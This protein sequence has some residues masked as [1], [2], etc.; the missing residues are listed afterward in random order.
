MKK[1]SRVILLLLAI[2]T[3][4]NCT[5]AY[6]TSSS[7]TINKIN[8]KGYEI[9]IDANGGI[10]DSKSV[11]VSKNSTDLP[12]PKRT[13]YSFSGYSNSATGEVLYS[14]NITNI[15]SI[16]NNQIYAKWNANSYVVD[17]NPI[18]DGTAY[19]SGLAGYTFDV[20]V[21]EV[22]VADDVIDWYQSVTYGNPVR[23]KTNSITGRN[24]SYDK[25]F[26][27][28]A[29]QLNINPAWTI[30]TYEGHFYLNGTHRLTTYNK[31][32]STISTPNTSAS[33]LGYDANFY[34]ISGYTP[35]TTWTQPD[36]AVGF[37]INIAEYN[38]YASFG[39]AGSNNATYQNNKLINAGYNF[40]TVN[41]GWGAVEC[42]GNYSKI[43]NLYNN[44]WNILPRSGNG[45]SIYKQISC[46]SGWS[47]V[48]R[49]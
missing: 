22:Q 33:A 21:N 11:V 38:C 16:N 29:E 46:D 2:F 27:V 49:R 8:T 4:L 42:S 45:Y 43:M 7:K 10:F 3:T 15:D 14:N 24:T 25:T 39:N 35:W 36:Y 17:V 48:Q 32:G 31:Y 18:I 9:R 19:N 41:S 47:N 34:Y 30:N 20:W 12:I 40:C 23:V 28:G 13:G 6:F 37:T 44:V 26:T 1:M 5:F